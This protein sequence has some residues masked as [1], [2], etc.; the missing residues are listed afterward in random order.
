MCLDCIRPLKSSHIKNAENTI[1]ELTIWPSQIRLR[2]FS[3]D[4]PQVDYYTYNNIIKTG[5]ELNEPMK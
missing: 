2:I 4:L 1:K 5:I 3:D